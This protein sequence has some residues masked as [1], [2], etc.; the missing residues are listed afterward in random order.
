MRC[1]VLGCYHTFI[2]SF[3]KKNDLTSGVKCYMTTF[4]LNPVIRKAAKIINILSKNYLYTLLSKIITLL[5]KIITLAL[6]ALS[7]TFKL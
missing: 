5:S 2:R 1:F 6:T 4:N 7:L 3:V